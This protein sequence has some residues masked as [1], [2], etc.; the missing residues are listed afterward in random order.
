MQNAGQPF[1]RQ[2]EIF[3]HFPESS[4][5]CY[6]RCITNIKYNISTSAISKN[7]SAQTFIHDDL[8]N[9][10]IWK[11]PTNRWL[12]LIQWHFRDLSQTPGHFH[13]FQ[14]NGHSENTECPNASE[15]VSDT[16]DAKTTKSKNK[17]TARSVAAVTDISPQ[18]S[19]RTLP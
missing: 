4:Q 1:F 2:H 7:F 15:L 17:P 6:P 3:R 19:T 13:I 14:R 18:T 16:T 9:V 8:I 10:K 11:P 12:T 5:H